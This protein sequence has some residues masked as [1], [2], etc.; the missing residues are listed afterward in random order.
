MENPPREKSVGSIWVTLT[1]QANTMDSSHNINPMSFNPDLIFYQASCISSL[2]V[3]GRMFG[4]HVS[5]FTLIALLMAAK[6][7]CTITWE[8]IN[9][10]RVIYILEKIPFS[11]QL[12]NGHFCKAL[13]TFFS[14]PLGNH[15]SWWKH[16]PSTRKCFLF[17]CMLFH[18]NSTLARGVLPTINVALCSLLGRRTAH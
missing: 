10:W 5:W 12:K 9:G 3:L 4:L 17:C 18:I 1:M 16:L 14:P 8:S 13:G 2:N 11:C 7:R 15:P 6:R